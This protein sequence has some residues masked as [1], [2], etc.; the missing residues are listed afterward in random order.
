[1]S[2]NTH[3]SAPCYE[4]NVTSHLIISP[5]CLPTTMYSI[6]SKKYKLK[7][8]SVRYFIRVVSGV[9]NIVS[10]KNASTE[11]QGHVTKVF[12][13]YSRNRLNTGANHT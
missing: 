8:V 2:R 5:P 12:I 3:T 13:I 4:G 1:M 6:L 11:K 7:V 9:T 10:L